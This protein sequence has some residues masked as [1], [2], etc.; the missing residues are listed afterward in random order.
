MGHK[1][2]MG[3]WSSSCP[4]LGKCCPGSCGPRWES[5]ALCRA[6]PGSDQSCL[7]FWQAL[8]ELQDT[9]L[10][11]CYAKILMENLWICGHVVRSYSESYIQS[12]AK[13]LRVRN[14]IQSTLYCASENSVFIFSRGHWIFCYP[15][16]FFFL[17][18][19]QVVLSW[20]SWPCL[21]NTLLKSIKR[22]A[23]GVWCLI[24]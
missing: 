7:V 6:H 24:S 2:Q 1:K 23:A 10:Q 5:L 15:T 11:K 4:C 3:K 16:S 18:I 13:C 21:H 19:Y 9:F 22:T 12:T 20:H 17:I 14:Y 8:L